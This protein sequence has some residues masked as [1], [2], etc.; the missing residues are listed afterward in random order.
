LQISNNPL[1]YPR[2]DTCVVLELAEAQ[3][4]TASN[5]S[6]DIMTSNTDTSP[7]HKHLERFLTTRHPP[8][9]FCPSE[10]ARA[11]SAEELSELG[12]GTWRDAMPEVRGLVYALRDEGGCEV[13]QKGQV[14]NEAEIDV[15][16]PI[17]VRRLSGNADGENSAI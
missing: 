9:T 3:P 5:F 8:K 6:A 12:F 14:I 4:T 13:L 11:L 16:G 7:L 10:V 1:Q 17:R 15:S 2:K